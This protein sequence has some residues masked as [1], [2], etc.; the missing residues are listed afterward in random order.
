MAQKAV[1]GSNIS[2]QIGDT[3]MK[4]V[5]TTLKLGILAGH[6]MIIDHRERHNSLV[7]GGGLETW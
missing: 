4:S 3:G 2:P 5:S 7:F 1:I 6:S